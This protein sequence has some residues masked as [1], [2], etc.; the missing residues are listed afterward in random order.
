[1]A[2]V[3]ESGMEGAVER[4]VRM[5]ASASIVVV[6]LLYYF[7]FVAGEEE[8]GGRHCGCLLVI[9]VEGQW[10]KSRRMF[11]KSCSIRHRIILFFIVSDL[12]IPSCSCR[13]FQ[14]QQQ[15]H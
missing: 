11:R 6:V 10:K 12:H 15:Q 4:V 14:E 1:M 5:S 3:K 8:E 2:K 9:H 13:S 7:I